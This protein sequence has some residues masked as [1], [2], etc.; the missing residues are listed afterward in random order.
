MLLAIS[1][2]MRRGEILSLQWKHVMLNA[3]CQS[4]LII[5]EH[6]KN[7]DQRGIPLVGTALLEIERLRQ[8]VIHA[9][10]G[11]PNPEALLFPS[12][13]TPGKSLEIR[14]AWDTTVRKAELDSHFK[15]HD[16]RH[17]AA[18]YLAMNGVMLRDI[19]EILGHKSMDMVKRYSHL[20]KDHLL[21]VM[22]QLNTRLNNETLKDK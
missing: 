19:A 12:D 18:S 3:D 7:E 11:K 16:L 21:G 13:R 9:N 8:I 20:S 1:T 17:T 4:A 14:K 22:T 10:H 15:F 2:G 6:T 5:L